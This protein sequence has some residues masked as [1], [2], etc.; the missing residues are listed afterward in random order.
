MKLIDP[1]TVEIHVSYSEPT[2]NVDGTPLTD[3]AYS[4]I[5][6]IT[7]TGTIK[8]PVV[9]ETSLQGGGKID[10]TVQ[11]NAPEGT[12]TI[13]KFQVS[14]T[15]TSGNEGPKTDPSVMIVDRVGPSAPTDFTIG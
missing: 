8:A 4:T 5:Y 14:A 10:T 9:K 2:T 3:L 12:K 11:V 6:V 13:L 1:Q 7:P 15:D